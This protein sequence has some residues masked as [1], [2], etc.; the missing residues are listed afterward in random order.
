MKSLPHRLPAAIAAAGMLVICLSNGA[1]AQPAADAE[2]FAEIPYRLAYQGWYTVSAAVN[3]DGPH[4][5]IV[6]SGATIT[7]VFE[8]L[9]DQQ[10]FTPLEGKTIQI[11]G[12]A[13][14]QELQSYRIGDIDFSGVEMTGHEGVILRDWEPP[15]LPPQ[16]VMGLDL[17]TRYAVY[18]DDETKTIRFYDPSIAVEKGRRWTRTRMTPLGAEGPGAKLF[19]IKLKAGSARI[20]C[21]VDLGASGTIFNTPALRAMTSGIHFS[22]AQGKDFTTG[23]RINDIFDTTD[24]A[25]AVQIQRIR[26]GGASWREKVFIIYDAKIFADLGYARKPFCLVGAD[27]FAGRSFMFDFAGEALYIGPQ[28]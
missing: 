12:L 10:D 7:S 1:A 11:V 21:I 5:F 24:R 19:M 4:D 3:G 15:N 17:L 13:G 22:A 26:I 9:A 28:T 8:N 25:R 27:L 2:P 18:V 20:P 14:T 23:S 16:G 6:D